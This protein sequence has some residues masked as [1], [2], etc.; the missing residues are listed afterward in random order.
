M[1]E[2][3]DADSETVSAQDGVVIRGNVWFE[4]VFATAPQ[5]KRKERRSSRRAA[6][7]RRRLAA[8]AVRVLGA[9]S[10]R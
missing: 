1:S 3:V 4:A 10:I 6:T 2:L 5:Q 8:C 7:L 9:S